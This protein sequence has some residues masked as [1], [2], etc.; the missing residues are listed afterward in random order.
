MNTVKEVAAKLDVSQV[1]VYNHLKKLK[2]D[3]KDNIK[4]IN[5]VTHINQ[6]GINKLEISM[7]LSDMSTVTK[8]ISI[9]NVVN[10]ISLNIINDTNKKYDEL[11]EY[12]KSN[13]SQLE[14]ELKEVKKQNQ[15]LISIIY[16]K[17][18]KSLLDKF[19]NLFK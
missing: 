10:E 4:K 19:K 3:I 9:E 5:G 13:N 6:E 17:K 8:T 12:I 2:K 7:G 1:T 16:D 11:K 14:K 15:I 18:N